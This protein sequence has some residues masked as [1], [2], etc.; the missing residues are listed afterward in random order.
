MPGFPS[1][2]PVPAA[3]F[4]LP[5]LDW[6][7][8]NRRKL[9][10]R[11]NPHWYRVW[12]SE[13]MLQ[14][15]TVKAVVPYFDAFLDRFPDV[16]TLAAA[17]EAEVLALWA[18]L[19]YYSRARQLLET[20]RIICSAHDGSF[21]ADYR[22]A[23]ALPGIGRYTAG[24]ILSIAFGLPYPV[25]E[26]NV[27][28]VFARYLA[29]AD[30]WDGRAARGLWNLLST[31]VSSSAIAD[32]AGDFNQALMELGATV[33]T[34]RHPDCRN[35]PLTLA[36]A[37]RRRSMQHSLPVKRQARS[38]IVLD[39]TVALVRQGQK[40]LMR[41]NQEAPFPKGLWELPRSNDE[42]LA[43]EIGNSLGTVT[44]GITHHL[45]R[46]QVVGASLVGASIPNGY[47]WID[48]QN[49]G[50]GLSGYVR[51]VLGRLQGQQGQQGQKG[52]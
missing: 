44:H 15:T 22:A 29:Y 50:V 12:V 27:S 31:I 7:H 14:Q 26:G 42:S 8:A 13:I 18:G 5:L 41:P 11:D 10:W 46:I 24:A 6:Y 16:R 48:P 47:R 23:L 38:V 35:C 25:V 43:L 28:R 20:A 32:R 21:P 52:R 51:K 17:E 36:C 34:P 49:P 1:Q 9:P 30:K 2:L 19:G 4:V 39:C 3:D 40:I 37:A 33:C 45:I